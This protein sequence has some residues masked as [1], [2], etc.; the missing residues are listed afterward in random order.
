[1]RIENFAAQR[2]EQRTGSHAAAIGRDTVER[3]FAAGDIHQLRAR[4][5]RQNLC[6]YSAH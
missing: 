2:D 3:D 4:Q 1:V 5:C 6:E